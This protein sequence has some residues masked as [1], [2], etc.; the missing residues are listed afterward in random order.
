MIQTIQVSTV[1]A[2]GQTN[3]FCPRDLHD[4]TISTGYDLPMSCKTQ[5]DP[6]GC[7]TPIPS[8]EV[9]FSFISEGGT[10]YFR[11]QPQTNGKTKLTSQTFMVHRHC[12]LP[13]PTQITK[14]AGLPTFLL[15][16]FVTIRS[17][18]Q[19]GTHA[20]THLLFQIFLKT[21]LEYH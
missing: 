10:S 14:V 17:F 13:L 4:T 16:C 7:Y 3:L 8:F 9:I 20:F 21:L 5:P 6:M 11:T 18:P 1:K 15:P 19:S 12:C 2:Q